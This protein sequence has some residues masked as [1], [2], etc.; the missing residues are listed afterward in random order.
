MK[1]ILSR[2]LVLAVSAS[3]GLLVH[4][5][6]RAT[7]TP[8]EYLRPMKN[9]FS[10]G[11]RMVGGANVTFSGALGATP[12]QISRARIDAYGYDDGIIS[13]DSGDAITG[14][15]KED[16]TNS[17]DW[18]RMNK[19][20]NHAGVAGHFY[21][22]LLDG[23]GEAVLNADGKQ[24][25]TGDY[26]ANDETRTRNWSYS[27]ASQFRSSA[28]D[29]IYD[30]VAMSAYS[31]D[32]ATET[33]ATASARDSRNPGIELTMG[34]VIQRFKRFEWGFTVGFGMS[35]FNAKT[36]Q[37]VA[38]KLQY[39]TDIYDIYNTGANYDEI[40]VRG[41]LQDTSVTSFPTFNTSGDTG[42]GAF[43]YDTMQPDNPDTDEDESK[44]NGTR[45]TTNPISK[46]ASRTESSSREDQGTDP[47]KDGFAEG[48]WQVKGVY[49]MLRAGPMVRVPIGK[50]FS[51]YVSAGYMAAYVGSKF[52]YEENVIIPD[53]AGRLSTA[54][55]VSD[56]YTT[57]TI[58]TK[59]NQQYLSGY[60]ADFNFEWWVSTRTG[61]YAGV[62][63]EHLSSYEQN[64]HSR[65]ATVKMDSG[66]G[67]RFGIMTRF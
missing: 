30:Q 58:D 43:Q 48:Y 34:R 29:G 17:V 59:T 7:V 53:S 63:Y 18:D 15:P 16:A 46:T 1:S 5:Q 67:W 65:K 9:S 28:N 57:T 33:G 26:L 32:G 27:G 60:Y 19:F 39:I 2:I 24:I 6:D 37:N 55:Q 61:F 49:Y 23:N 36:R 50:R 35:E 10:I 12:F 25:M 3:T 62:A 4:A 11:V 31:S 51:A 52:R 66:L 8:V 14:R 47:L 56:G 54:Y 64:L 13:D 21:T 45:E 41:P 40:P 38:V 44:A 20:G 22:I 42:D